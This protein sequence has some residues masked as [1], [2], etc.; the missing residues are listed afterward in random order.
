MRDHGRISS[1]YD[2]PNWLTLE[3]LIPPSP[4]RGEGRVRGESPRARVTEVSE[5]GS[6]PF[7]QVAND[8]DRPLLLLDGEELIGAKQNRIL[9]TTVLVAAHTEVTIPVSCVEQGRWGYRGRQFHP[10]DASLYAS[11][12][13]QKAAHVSQSVRAGRGHQ[14]VRR[15]PER[16]PAD[17]M[18]RL[19]TVEAAALR[20]QTVISNAPA[21][22]APRAPARGLL[23]Q[24]FGFDDIVILTL[25][26]SGE[27]VFSGRERVGG[28]NLRRFTQGY[29]L[30]GNQLMTPGKLLFESVRRFKG[31]QAPAIVLVEVDPMA[32]KGEMFQRLLYSGMTR[33][34]VRLELVVKADNPLNQSLLSHG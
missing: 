17:F 11:L 13:A 6:V 23:E 21:W 7:L 25:R 27:S 15:N 4:P 31:Q 26:G 19:A 10:G 3:D 22:I 1:R 34:T 2:D 14:A 20:S 32:D 8:A 24:G 29:D 18:F 28:Y 33:A 12:R 30:F 9:N 16:F 5:A